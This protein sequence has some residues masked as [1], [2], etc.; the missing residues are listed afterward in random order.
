MVRGA[1]MVGA[2]RGGGG[3]GGGGM[4]GGRGTATEAGGTHST[5]MHFSSTC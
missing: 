5:G 3:G 4:H 2:V 1:C